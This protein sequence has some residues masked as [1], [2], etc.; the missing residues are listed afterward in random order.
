MFKQFI[1]DKL[2]YVGPALRTEPTV[3]NSG[4]FLRLEALPVVEVPNIAE[5]YALSVVSSECVYK[6][7]DT[8]E[9]YIAEN[10]LFIAY[11][12][13]ASQKLRPLI[14]D[15]SVFMPHGGD[16]RV[17]LLYNLWSLRSDLSLIKRLQL[18]L[19]S[20]LGKSPITNA[21]DLS[22]AWLCVNHSALV[23]QIRETVGPDGLVQREIESAIAK[24]GISIVYN[25][26]SRSLTFRDGDFVATF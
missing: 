20:L 13:Y 8:Q 2:F 1:T 10:G 16:L 5:L 14:E 25:P 19:R 12:P 23:K 4:L 15:D 18:D 7:L 22:T 26:K 6:T 9:L 24:L 3:D 11:Q 21:Y 17:G